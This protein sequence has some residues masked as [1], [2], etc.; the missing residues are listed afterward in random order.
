MKA[1]Q[2][3]LLGRVII[4]V[5]FTAPIFV[6]QLKAGGSEMISNRWGTPSSIIRTVLRWFESGEIWPHIVSTLGIAIAGL[7]IGGL[8]GILLGYLFHSNKVLRQSLEPLMV[9]LNSLPRILLVPIFIAAFGIGVLG[10][11]LMVV[12]M[13]VFLFFFNVLNGLDS[14]NEKLIQNARIL[15]AGNRQL[16]LHV[17]L[18]HLFDWILAGLRP[19]I[20][21]AFIGA[22]ISEYMGATEGMGYLVDLAYGQDRYDEAVAGILVILILAGLIDLVTRY[23]ERRWRFS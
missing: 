14:V 4:L 9:W 20:G 17:Q 22:I 16:F 3:A 15:G 13:T 10:K 7:V 8:G 21:F 6:W 5:L 18:P 11:L 2:K 23:A 19:A 12:A 1:K